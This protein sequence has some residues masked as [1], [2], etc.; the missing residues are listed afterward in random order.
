[1]GGHGEWGKGSGGERERERSCDMMRYI[2]EI[3]QA[4]WTQVMNTRPWM[5]QEY[6]Q[7]APDNAATYVSWNDC[8]E[9]IARLNACGES[10][11]RLPTEAEWEHA[12]IMGIRQ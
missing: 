10:Q 12:S 11:Y 8:Q 3:T 6:A 4:Q 9:F 5:G 1:M 2:Y 7:D